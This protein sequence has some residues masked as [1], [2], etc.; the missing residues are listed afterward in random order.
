M[1][2]LHAIALLLSAVAIVLV[3]QS[4]FS[5]TTIEGLASGESGTI[6]EQVAKATKGLDGGAELMRNAAHLDKDKEGVTAMIASYKS[7]LENCMAAAVT[8]MATAT[9]ESLDALTSDASESV[10]TRT[11]MAMIKDQLKYVEIA[12]ASLGSSA[13]VIG[14][15][16]GGWIA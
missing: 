11:E 12:Q 4:A 9:S 14:K 10:K 3:L 13:P 5:K 7:F 2:Y 8:K 1:Q 15:K 16:M 6:A